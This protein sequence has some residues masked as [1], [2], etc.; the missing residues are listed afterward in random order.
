MPRA[1]RRLSIS[2]VACKVELGVRD[3]KRAIRSR[4]SGCW[5]PTR[6]AR[7]RNRVPTVETAQFVVEGGQ[8]VQTGD[9]LKQDTGD[10]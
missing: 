7:R 4:F 6:K 5:I 8:G 1:K 9:L 2:L 10:D 3:N